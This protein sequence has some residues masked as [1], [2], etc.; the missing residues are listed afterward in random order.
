MLLKSD[1]QQE[2]LSATYTLSKD[3]P[4]QCPGLSVASSDLT[5]ESCNRIRNDVL[6]YGEGLVPQPMIMDLNMW[7]QQNMSSYRKQVQSVQGPAETEQMWLTLLS[8]DHMRSKSK[9]IKTIQKWT[10]ELGLTGHL[11]FVDKDILILLCGSQ[12]SIKVR[13]KKQHWHILQ[14]SC[15]LQKP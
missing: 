1:D 10:S 8:L 5:K 13:M 3:Y 9:Y 12:E 11:I 14:S 4:H 15:Q 6:K 2:Q 7:I